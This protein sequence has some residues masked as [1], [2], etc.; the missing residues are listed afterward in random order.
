MMSTLNIVQLE[1]STELL[2]TG[3]ADKKVKIF[4]LAANGNA[5]LMLEIDVDATPRSLD[6][7]NGKLLI[8]LQ[9]GTIR[10][11]DTALKTGE[12]VIRS[13]YDGE[14][15]G[16]CMIDEENTNKFLTSGDDNMILLHD[17]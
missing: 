16:L 7:M 3:G 9:N 17:I 5:T 4:S 15:W 10:E 2:L 11:Y 1:D 6:Y 8:G 12:D 14:V 13:H